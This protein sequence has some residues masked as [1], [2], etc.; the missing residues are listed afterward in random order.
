[1]ENSN[2]SRELNGAYLSFLG[3]SCTIATMPAGLGFSE[4]DCLLLFNREE[5][6]DGDV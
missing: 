2:L 3:E 4:T 6:P 5:D 1:M